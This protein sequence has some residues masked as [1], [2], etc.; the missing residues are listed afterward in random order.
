MYRVLLGAE[1]KD[2]ISNHILREGQEGNFWVQIWKIKTNKI[3]LK[4]VE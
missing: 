2:H 4:A 1:G 3:C